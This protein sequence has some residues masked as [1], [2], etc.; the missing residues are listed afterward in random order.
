MARTLMPD[1][2]VLLPGILGS[3]LE[4]NGKEIWGLSAGSVARA[5]AT[6][7]GSIK[8]LELHD[9][10]DE[11]I[12]IGDGVTA[13]RVLP[14]VHMVPGLWKID[15]YTK[16]ATAIKKVFAVT[17]G[18][19]YFEFPYDWR[20][21]NRVAAL[22]LQ[23]MTKSWLS[24]WKAQGH[25]NARLILIGH[26]MGGLVARYFLEVLGGW[27]IT[28][29]LIT[30]GTPHRGS[31]N[32]LNFIANGWTKSVLGVEVLD[33]SALLRSLSSVYELL[34]IYECCLVGGKMKY[35]RDTQIPHLNA[36]KLSNAAKFHDAI[37]NGVASRGKKFDDRVHPVVGTLQP[38]LQSAR[39]E[40]G[41]VEVVETFDGK[42][43]SGDGTV[44]RV[45][46]TP[47]ELSDAGR[48][49]FATE[50]HASLQNNDAVWA[51]VEGI[52]KTGQIDLNAFKVPQVRLSVKL[53]DAYSTK[54][55]VRLCARPDVETP[56][57]DAIVTNIE[58]AQSKRILTLKITGDGWY[59]AESEP[60][61]A[62]AYRVTVYG[63]TRVVPV[64]DIFLVA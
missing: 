19:N 27:E 13:P 59:E 36:S 56:T 31:L 57:L 4:K 23:R 53:D 21:Q 18:Q 29:T 44:P 35:I 47:I 61:T 52:L 38:T 3:V 34:P 22:R 1:V 7:G 43:M 20:R 2:I 58:H 48:D 30:F 42:D 8:D 62:G 55:P 15:G 39:F 40:N 63:D 54:E 9:D 49:M 16:I 32:A 28:R 12:D 24:G 60:L 25:P 64:T 37:R 51:Q 41:V 5:F 14:D 17:E 26:S 50:R 6:F 10:P 45:S 33:L 46:A 11:D